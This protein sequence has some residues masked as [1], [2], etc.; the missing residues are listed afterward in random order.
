M[1]KLHHV[2]FQNRGP[3]PLHRPLVRT[4]NHGGDRRG[5]AERDNHSP[6]TVR[7][8]GRNARERKKQISGNLMFMSTLLEEAL[9]KVASLPPDDQDAIA[10]QILDTLED[11]ENWR[12]INATRLSAIRRMEQEAVEEDD[13]G[14]T[15]PMDELLDRI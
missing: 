4:D 1:A 15:R 11:R 10:A 8:V 2:A 12:Q 6:V 3:E 13:R 9:E 5:M 14:L 7:S